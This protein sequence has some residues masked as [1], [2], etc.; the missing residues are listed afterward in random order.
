MKELPSGWTI[1]R[2]GEE[3]KD[4]KFYGFNMQTGLRLPPR[5][6][7]DE[8]VQDSWKEAGPRAQPWG[9]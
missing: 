6:K 5:V 3:G 7:Y 2:L 9:S 8:A 4:D 1:V